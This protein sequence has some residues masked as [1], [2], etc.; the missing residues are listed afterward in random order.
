MVTQKL[1]NLQ[2][3]T[4]LLKF[5]IEPV[6]VCFWPVTTLLEAEIETEKSLNSLVFIEL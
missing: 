4:Q 6:E 3:Q 2:L 1:L 5:I